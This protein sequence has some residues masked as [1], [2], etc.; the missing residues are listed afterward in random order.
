[1]R[2]DGDRYIH[3]GRILAFASKPN[4]AYSLL[5]VASLGVAWYILTILPGRKFRWLKPFVATI[6]Q[7]LIPAAG[8]SI[9]AGFGFGI[10]RIGPFVC[11]EGHWF[12]RGEYLGVYEHGEIHALRIPKRIVKCANGSSIETDLPVPLI[13]RIITTP[14][15]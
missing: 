15:A 9:F 5:A 10:L 2:R 6:R 7:L 12:Q 11:L 3:E 8:A 4:L 13:E 1:M 14:A